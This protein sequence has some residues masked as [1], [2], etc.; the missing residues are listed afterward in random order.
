MLL[1]FLFVYDANFPSELEKIV[2]WIFFKTG[3][4]FLKTSSQDPVSSGI[5]L[6]ATVY[7]R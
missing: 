5:A 4:T 1:T 6:A 3:V 7:G 2:K